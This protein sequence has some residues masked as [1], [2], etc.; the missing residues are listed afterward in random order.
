[1]EMQS[2][3]T[4]YREMGDFIADA[5]VL[6]AQLQDG[7]LQVFTETVIPIAHQFLRD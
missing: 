6:Q 7:S 3:M 4:V 1:M 2:T 5:R